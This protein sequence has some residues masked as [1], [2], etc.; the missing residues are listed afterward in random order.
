MNG[1]RL[2]QVCLVGI[3]AL[4]A[5]CG[6]SPS[7]MS[8]PT[9]EL[10]VYDAVQIAQTAR[11]EVELR[12]VARIVEVSALE[13]DVQWVQVADDGGG[14][15][16]AIEHSGEVQYVDLATSLAAQ[17]PAYCDDVESCGV[18]G[19]EFEL[20]SLALAGALPQP[21]RSEAPSHYRMYKSWYDGCVSGC[22]EDWLCTK[23]CEAIYCRLT[24]C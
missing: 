12:G 10:V 22:A 1:I 17:E 23:T 4:G 14:T 21:D 7:D 24:V 8:D 13:D 19:T 18:S 9:P 6:S 20:V 16:G 11:Y 15:L 5:G 3:S 2:V